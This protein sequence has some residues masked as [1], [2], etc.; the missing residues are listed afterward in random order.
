MGTSRACWRRPDNWAVIS[1]ACRK[2]EDLGE[3]SF[4]QQDIEFSAL[5]NKKRKAGKDC[6]ELVW[7]Y[8]KRCAVSLFIPTS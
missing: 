7:Q 3:P 5:G 4:M 2:Q 1:S 6:T 8:R